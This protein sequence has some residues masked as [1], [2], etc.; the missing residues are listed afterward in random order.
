MKKIMFNDKYGL[1]E[2]VIQGRKTMTRRNIPIG[3]YNRIDFKAYGE[4]D[5]KCFLNNDDDNLVDYR[6]AA[7]YKV[8]EIVAISQRYADLNAQGLL[9]DDSKQTLANSAGWSNKQSVKANLM[10]HQILITS[11]RLERLQDISEKDC[12]KEG[13][14][15]TAKLAKWSPR[16]EFARL[17]DKVN[18][19]G[20]WARNDYVWVY[21]FE[22]VK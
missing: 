12:T 3:I 13:V 8:G 6:Y 16:S 4:G 2:A 14:K 7:Y 22:L 9:P 10:P 1:T 20:T 18:G 11:V 15:N 19:K 5:E 21:E 17:I